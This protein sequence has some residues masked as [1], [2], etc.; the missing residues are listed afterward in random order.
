MDEAFVAAY[1]ATSN[2]ALAARYG[3]SEVTILKWAR[4][5]GLRK[6]ADYRAAVQRSNAT[7][8]VKSEAAR[9]KIAASRRGR[10]APPGTGAKIVATKRARGTL[11]AGDRHYRW[12]GGRPWERFRDERY[13]AWRRAVLERDGY[14][15]QRCGRRCKRYER[16]LAAHHVEPYASHPGL[17]YDVGNGVTLCRMCHLMLHGNAPKPKEPVPCACGC[18][19]MISPVDAYDAYGRPRRY[20]VGHARR[21][22]R[23]DELGDATGLAG[24]VAAHLDGVSRYR[25]KQ[26]ACQGGSV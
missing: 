17:R 7:G 2:A 26:S 3:K 12:K 23:A 25:K 20:L 11:A 22:G 18:G 19:A 6:S 14:V 16:G 4:R 21:R 5:L 13:L 9:A 15:C 24:G 8:K 1:P 10:P